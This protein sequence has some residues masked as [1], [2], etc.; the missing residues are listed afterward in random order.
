M[1]YQTVSQLPNVVRNGCMKSYDQDFIRIFNKVFAPTASE[2]RNKSAL[3]YPS[4]GTDFVTPIILGLPF[5]REFYFYEH[6]PL[7]QS[8]RNRQSTMIEYKSKL[9]EI[10]CALKKI[11]GFNMHKRDWII[12]TD[13]AFIKFN[14]DEIERTIHWVHKDNKDFLHKD[15]NLTFYFHRGDSYGEGGSGQFWDSDLLPELMKKVPND[16]RCL[17]VTDG[18]PR[19]LLEP[20]KEKAHV[21]KIH[22][23]IG[24]NYY[25]GILPSR[26]Q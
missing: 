9:K 12:K 5:C 13:E 18:E 7:G 21:F 19:G 6:E 8:N 24:G 25:F 14:Y 3:F 2:F 22:E 26:L 23:N 15:V 10:T 16:Y 11:N 20:V 4:S 17:F 1:E